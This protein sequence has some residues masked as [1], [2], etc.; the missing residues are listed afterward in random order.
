MNAN[1]L[2]APNLYCFEVMADPSSTA[3]ANDIFTD[4]DIA[5]LF[6]PFQSYQSLLIAVSGGA[7][8]VAL[9]LL[10]ARWARQLTEPPVIEVA[11]I[12]H[13]LREDSQRE[14]TWVAELAHTLGLK[15]STRS[16]D[17]A[18]PTT[19]LQAAARKARYRLLLQII[20]EGQLPAPAA[21]VTA[22]TE[23]DQ[24]ETVV[25]RLARGSGVD[26]LAAMVPARALHGDG[27]DVM[28]VRPFLS[29]PKAKL[30]EFL[31]AAQQTW[32]EDPSNTSRDFERI[33]LRQARDS[34]D[35]LGV[36][37]QALSLTAQ[38]A[39]RAR[40]ALEAQTQVFL[41][42]AVALHN[43]AFAEVDASAF[44]AQPDEI[45]IRTLIQLLRGF[46]GVSPQAQLQK[47]EALQASLLRHDALTTTLG[48]CVV[49]KT[50]SPAGSQLRVYREAGRAP[51]P[52]FEV[53]PGDKLDWDRRFQV[54]I[55]DTAV[56]QQGQIT[57]RALDGAAFAALR[58]HLPSS[59]AKIP[60]A[61]AKTLPSFWCDDQLLAVPTLNI[62]QA[63]S[64]HN[65]TGGAAAGEDDRTGSGHEPCRGSYR[66]SFI[67]LAEPGFGT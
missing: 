53:L 46:G 61:A 5:V 38:R 2:A 56:A 28:L 26:G 63:I 50:C 13:Q 12:D 14:A 43:G 41:S 15:H 21:V 35:A 67:G 6:A 39:R 17:A 31:K 36:T 22:H 16:W 52:T 1:V 32:L 20:D 49:S 62:G 19:G 4:E 59:C 34:L 9:L 7:D 29:V 65:D 8:S 66:A 45:Q 47:I 30:I 57:V 27:E 25:M 33:R 40:Q 48:G 10:L 64:V 58:S 42:D 44:A 55:L 23:D 37:A 60:S 51:L 11:T 3:T 24:A 54:S 18:K